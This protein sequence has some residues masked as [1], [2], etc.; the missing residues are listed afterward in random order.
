ML[1]VY[2]LYI[3]YI[4]GGQGDTYVLVCVKIDRGR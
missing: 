3:F 1:Y 2:V 4:A